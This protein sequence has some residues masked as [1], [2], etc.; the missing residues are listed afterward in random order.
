MTLHLIPLIVGAAVG[1][2]GTYIYKDKASQEK[3]K[4]IAQNATDKVKSFVKREKV[5]EVVETAEDVI[6]AEPAS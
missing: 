3:I 2:L 1:S 5:G 4:N 6:D